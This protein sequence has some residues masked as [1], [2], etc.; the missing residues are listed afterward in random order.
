MK[1]ESVNVTDPETG[2]VSIV[3]ITTFMTAHRTDL[4][5]DREYIVNYVLIASTVLVTVIPML[6]MLVSSA[7]IY[8]VDGS[9]DAFD[10]L[11]IVLFC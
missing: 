5:W 8:K 6:C 2:E 7:L 11:R 10:K 9:T 1:T 4:R 3:N